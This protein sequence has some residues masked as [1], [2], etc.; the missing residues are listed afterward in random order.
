[1]SIGTLKVRAAST[2]DSLLI[3]ALHILNDLWMGRPSLRT[4]RDLSQLAAILGPAACDE[5]FGRQHLGDYWGHL[6]DVVFAG[7]S[8]PSI[9]GGG[10]RRARSLGQTVL[11]MRLSLLGWYGASTVARHP[12]S[13]VARLSVP[14]AAAFALATT[15]PSRSYIRANFGTYPAYWAAISRATQLSL[16]GQDVRVTPN[17]PEG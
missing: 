4:W 12:A 1:M 2:S 7:D 17:P 13:W 5:A 8:P 16:R 3:A 14:R 6:R 15:V 10:Q 9:E 11:E